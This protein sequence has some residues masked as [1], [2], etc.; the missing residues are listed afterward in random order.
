MRS[1]TRQGSA[2][3][4]ILIW[5]TLAIVC[6]YGW[7]HNIVVVVHHI[8]EPIS[9]MFILRVAGIPVAPLGVVLGYIGN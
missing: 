9:G 5:L 2:G 8:N 6:A 4:F 1:P 7:I 3:L